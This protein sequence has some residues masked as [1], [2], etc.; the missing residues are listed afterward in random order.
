MVSLHTSDLETAK[1]RYPAELQRVTRMIASA[2]VTMQRPQGAVERIA[3]R[4]V[5]ASPLAD[6]EDYRD[7][8]KLALVDLLQKLAEKVSLTLEE[9]ATQR[10]AEV[11]INDEQSPEDAAQNPPLSAVFDLWRTERNPS[12]KSWLEF[13]RAL[14][15]F[16]EAVRRGSMVSRVENVHETWSEGPARHRGF[17]IDG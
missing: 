13:R 1:M 11:L 10:A 7:A 12:M 4:L 2:R 6:H 3:Q 16:V 17:V 8:E 5:Q 15:A 14:D 9:K